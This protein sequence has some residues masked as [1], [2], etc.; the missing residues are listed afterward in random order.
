MQ[1]ESHTR[2]EYNTRD[3][4]RPHT[5]ANRMCL[6]VTWQVRAETASEPLASTTRHR[7]PYMHCNAQK[8]G[9]PQAAAAAPTHPTRC[10]AA[11]TR[12]AEQRIRSSESLC[13]T[14]GRLGVRRASG[15]K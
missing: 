12:Q 8:P 2:T 11:L 7:H 6:T 15:C 13:S 1:L 14:D 3:S 5:H 4:E 9:H 10:P